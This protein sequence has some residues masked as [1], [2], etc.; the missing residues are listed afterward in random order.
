MKPGTSLVLCYHRVAEGAYDPFRLCVTPDRFRAH[1]EEL[2]RV[3]KFSTLDEITEPCGRP[4]VV[5]TFDDGY[6]DNLWHA[7]PVAQAV[8][9]PFTVFVI[10]GQ[11]GS[12]EG[13][14]WDRMAAVLRRRPPGRSSAVLDIG[15]RSIE[16]RLGAGLPADCDAVR[17]ELLPLPVHEIERVLSGL[18]EGW[19]V[20]SVAPEDA[21]PLTPDELQ[22]LARADCARIGAHTTDH[23]RLHGRPAAEQLATIA[24]S[25]TA[26]ETLTGRDV[27]D[28]AYPFGGEDDFDDVSVEQVRAAGLRTACTTLPGLAT[29]G[30]DLLHLPRRLVMN[31]TR[32]RLRVQLVRWQLW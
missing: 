8:G 32:A 22:T 30:C 6:G 29:S 31:W 19:G 2:S 15:G 20:A 16:V 26:L 28:F 4:R 1:L 7:L 25:K 21:L 3:A 12:R 13:Y 11:L 23:V 18:A 14:W 10:S 27:R 9:A 5:V 24:G 17:R